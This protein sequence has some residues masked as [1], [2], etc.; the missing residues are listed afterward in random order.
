MDSQKRKFTAIYLNEYGGITLHHFD[1]K[2]EESMQEAI[3]RTGIT[4]PVFY[5]L[6]EYVEIFSMRPQLTGDTNAA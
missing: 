2:H 3:K 6:Y 5:I 4:R 1:K